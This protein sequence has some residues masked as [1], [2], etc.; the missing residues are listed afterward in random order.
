MFSSKNLQISQKVFGFMIGSSCSG[1]G[2]GNPP[3]D[4]KASGS[5][6]DD[7]PPTMGVVGSSGF[8]FG[9]GRVT[10]VGRVSE[11]GGQT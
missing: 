6:G 11:L 10:R 9:F 1:F 4:P 2:I 5:V 3:T 7:P 8:Q